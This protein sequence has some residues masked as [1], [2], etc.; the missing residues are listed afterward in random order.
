MEVTQ[1]PECNGSGLQQCLY[2]AF[3]LG[4][5]NWVLGFSNGKKIRYRTIP[6]RSM[7]AFFYEMK[8]A[9]EKLGLPNDVQI[10]SCY[11]AG[12][13]GF[14]L[15]R[16]LEEN[17]I[18]NLVVDSSSIEVNRKARRQKSDRMDANKLVRM[19]IRY[20]N[21]EEQVWSVLRI[22]SPETEDEKRLHREIERL[23][24]EQTA[25]T[26]R[27]RSLLCTHGIVLNRIETSPQWLLNCKTRDNRPLGEGLRG[28]L[29]RELK[30]LQLVR[31]QL[32]EV[33]LEKS[34]ILKEGQSESVEK[35]RKLLKIRGIGPV[36]SWN[37][38]FE[39]FW[40]D[41]DNRKQ[42]AAAAG[43]VPSKFQSGK[44]DKD[45]GIS[46]EGNR[47]VRSL[48]V[49]ISW[50]WLRYQPQSNISKWYQLRFGSGGSKRIKK[51]GIVALARKLLVALWKYLE[52]GI[53]PEG[54]VV[55][56]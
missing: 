4:N 50:L 5:T 22:P 12:R 37:L 35:S 47:R 25:H 39:F 27:I 30:R 43:L 16:V 17:E 19:L 24:K 54:A 45:L 38:V 1:M 10:V 6:A 13:D 23:Q 40:R 14:W 3:E 36:S 20:I 18:Q 31:E 42:V 34:K 51:V 28:E 21:G 41:F 9:I 55:V 53:V 32:K 52:K 49:E 46:K 48:M 8:L 33:Q 7:V 2:I 11:E 15:D 29:V 44:M 56:A 26:N